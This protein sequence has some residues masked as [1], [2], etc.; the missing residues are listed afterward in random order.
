MVRQM[1]ERCKEGFTLGQ[2]WGLT[3]LGF[4]YFCSPIDLVPD[5]IP[6]LGWCDDWVVVYLLYKVW[7]GPTIASGPPSG[8]HPAQT[9]LFETAPR[10]S[11]RAN[12][13]ALI[14]ERA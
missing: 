10:E 12:C 5:V 6:V 4:V 3:I 2:K 14:P 13:A 8:G 9:D 7:A 1:I 11:G